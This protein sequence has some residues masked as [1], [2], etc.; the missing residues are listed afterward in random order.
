VTK[1]SGETYQ[2]YRR[3]LSLVSLAGS[4]AH[5]PIKRGSGIKR[6]VFVFSARVHYDYQSSCSRSLCKCNI[7]RNEAAKA[8]ASS[9]ARRGMA[10]LRKG[11]NM[12][13]MR[14]QH[15]RHFLR[16]PPYFMLAAPSGDE[17][18]N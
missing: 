8:G 1:H 14:P 2:R 13:T 4:R 3:S 10:L 18:P 7:V 5:P 6:L 11:C 16:L 9:A 17:W 12:A 15:C